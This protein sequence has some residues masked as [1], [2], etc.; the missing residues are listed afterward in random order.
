M[1]NILPEHLQ[2][3]LANVN[4]DLS[5]SEKERIKELLCEFSDVF[6]G[7]DGSFGKTN[8]VEHRI[9]TGEHAPIKIP[10]R[11]VSPVKKLAIDKEVRSMLDKNVI[12][13]SQSPWAAPVVLVTKSDGSIRFCNDYRKLNSVTKKDAF[14]LPR[15]DEALQTLAHAKYFSTLDLA[16]GYWQVKMVD[17]DKEKNGFCYS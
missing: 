11:R 10:P 16:S 7:P 15:I 17:E 2:P 13:H 8:V 3:L 14:P 6:V 4:S 1:G 5:D 12:E 9:D